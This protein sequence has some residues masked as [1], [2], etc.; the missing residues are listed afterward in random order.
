MARSTSMT[1]DEILADPGAAAAALDSI[2]KIAGTDLP[3][4][5]LPADDLVTLPGGH[6]H[7][8]EV[9]RTAVVRELNGADEEALAKA[10]QGGNLY[11]LLD[12]LISRGVVK[13]GNLS[14]E[15]TQRAVPDLL[16]GDRDELILGIRA[17]TYG[18]QIEVFGWTCP[19]CNG[20]VDKI[21]FS[22]KE[23][24]ERVKLK[25]PL[26]ETEFEIKLN[27]G[28]K[29]KVR[30]ATGAVQLAVWE[31]DGLV[32]PQR[33]DIL[34]S[35]TVQT[36]T[37]RRGQEH[38]IS[39]WPSMVREMTAPDRR[40][41]IRELTKRQPGPRYNDVRFTHDGCHEEVALALGITDLFRDLIA[42][43]V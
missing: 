7:K 18:E 32:G 17:A 37:D 36:Y 5:D 24:V 39:L 15:E 6:I 23:D 13:L 28:A 1:R 14:P 38:V 42:G 26:E 3:V 9:I 4:A 43:L 12:T 22:L 41:I 20:V 16:V 30:L 40:A 31:Q 29:A 2:N 11:H 25:N 8:G 34:L 21:E 19:K 27:R 10:L 35:K 33:D